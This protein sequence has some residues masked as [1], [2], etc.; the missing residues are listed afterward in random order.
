M[1]QHISKASISISKPAV[2]SVPRSNKT[3]NKNAMSAK[4]RGKQKAIEDPILDYWL[5]IIRSV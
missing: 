1:S 2:P 5:D 4:S 3:V